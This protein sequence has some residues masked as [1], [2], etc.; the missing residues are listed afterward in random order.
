MSVWWLVSIGA[1]FPA[2]VYV[3]T[4]VASRAFFQEKLRFHN[5]ILRGDLGR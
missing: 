2:L 1:V 3:G 4:R 5:L